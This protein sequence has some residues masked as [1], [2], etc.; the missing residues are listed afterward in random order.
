M[1]ENAY[2]I[3]VSPETETKQRNFRG[4][5][6]II[7][8]TAKSQIVKSWPD[9][10]FWIYDL[11]AAR[12]SYPNSNGE[13]VLGS[14][15]IGVQ[16]C[17]SLGMNFHAYLC[18]LLPDNAQELREFF[19]PDGERVNVLCG[20]SSERLPHYL[21]IAGRQRFGYVYAD[22][23]D[24]QLPVDLLANIFR[25][26]VFQRTDLIINIAAASLK[27]LI[28]HEAYGDI[29]LSTLLRRIDK[30]YWLVREPHGKHQWTFIVGTNWAD[31]PDWGKEGFYRLESTKGQETW[32]V[33]AL[34]KRQAKEQTQPA[35]FR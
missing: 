15:T 1:T 35:L 29:S 27:R 3:C 9:S 28:N 7:M 16:M 4:L 31:F 22:P 20:D 30:K 2:G 23:N 24:A 34:T 21:P 8:T 11:N 18:E 5:L 19:E 26:S 32:Q 6:R 10:R 25:R 12:S 13:M 17:K 33:V 14:S